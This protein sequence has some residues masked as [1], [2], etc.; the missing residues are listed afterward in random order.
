MYIQRHV[1]QAALDFWEGELR[2]WAAAGPP[3]AGAWDGPPGAAPAGAGLDLVVY[4]GPTPTR[5]VLHEFELWLAPGATDGK[6]TAARGAAREVRAGGGGAGGV[7]GAGAGKRGR[8][9]ALV[10]GR[11]SAAALRC[12]GC[13]FGRGPVS[14]CWKEQGGAPPPRPP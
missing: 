8:G 9:C 14:R 13:L 7:E 6:A 4:A 1:P 2:L 12:A 11:G 3:G 5:A 10:R